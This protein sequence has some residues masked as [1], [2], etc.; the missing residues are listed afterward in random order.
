[1]EA[2]LKSALCWIIVV[3]LFTAAVN[4]DEIM[5]LG[6]VK[7][8][9]TGIGRT[10]FKGTEIEEFKVE[11]LG[12]IQSGGPRQ[13]MILAKLSGGPLEKTGVIQGMSGS[14]VYVG[15]RLIGAVSSSFPFSTEAIA[16]IT[17]IEEMISTTSSNSPTPAASTQT[18]AAPI[19]GIKKMLTFEELGA[20]FRRPAEAG[21]SALT[22]VQTPVAIS[23]LNQATIDAFMPIFR[24]CNVTPIAGG[25]TNGTFEKAINQSREP[26]KPGSAISV[27][28]I[29]GDMEFSYI[30]TVTYIDKDRVYAFGHPVFNMGPTQFPMAQAE[31]IALLPN[32]NSSFKIA[33]TTTVVG[34]IE[35]DR[36]SAI[37]GRIGTRARMIPMNIRIETSMN[38]KEQY[39]FEIVSDKNLTH[40]LALMATLSAITSRERALGQ[41]TLRMSASI[42]LDTGTPVIVSDLFAGDNTANGVAYTLA[43]ALY[44]ILNNPYKTVTV[45]S[46][47][48]EVHAEETQKSARLDRIDFDRTAYRPGRTVKM[49][50]HLRGLN[51]E[52]IVEEASFEMPKSAKPGE[53]ILY[54]GDGQTLTSLE[55]SD[56]QGGD[57]YPQTYSQLIRT[58]N[59]QRRNNHIYFRLLDRRPGLVMRGE[60]M[61]DLPPSAASIIT[62]RGNTLSSRRMY[63]SPI[64]DAELPTDYSIDGYRLLQIKIQDF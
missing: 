10:V 29:R 1:M 31:V 20:A 32:L 26:L 51:D 17:P 39:R 18:S 24:S 41:N 14:P 12:V 43:T 49:K 57:L 27:Q 59:N 30:G 6:E 48:M 58:L 8:G 15:N 35:Q 33:S 52:P 47:D 61:S 19:A 25:N 53:L 40:I 4:G 3:I 22:Y 34:T 50:V 9:M 55:S 46:I 56:L 44:Y 60:D 7:R 38:S 11:I 16:G 63:L 36:S 23:G 62:S 5:P 28:L 21:S 42:N 2:V 54:I 37:A 64:F 13:N 45:N